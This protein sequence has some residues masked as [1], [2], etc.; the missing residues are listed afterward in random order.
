MLNVECG[1]GESPATCDV[2][3]PKAPSPKPRA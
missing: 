3:G 2:I 1:R